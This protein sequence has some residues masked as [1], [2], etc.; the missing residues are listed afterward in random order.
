MRSDGGDENCMLKMSLD[1]A[2]IYN[3]KSSGITSSDILT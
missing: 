1:N 3:K 2:N